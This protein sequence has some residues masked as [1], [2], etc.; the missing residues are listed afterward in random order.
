MRRAVVAVA[1]LLALAVGGTGC[2]QQT[3]LARFCDSYDKGISLITG[4]THDDLDGYKAQYDAGVRSLATAAEVAPT[5]VKVAVVRER[6][7]A[8][9]V[10]TAVQ[11][12]G[13]PADLFAAQAKD[14]RPDRDANRARVQRWID[15]HCTVNT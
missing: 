8:I 1:V 10:N 14:T 5:D 4:D 13:K 3:R 12:S 9:A 6:D 15:A 7:A 11:Q 2:A